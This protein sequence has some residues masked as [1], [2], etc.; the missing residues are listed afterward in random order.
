MCAP[1]IHHVH[2]PKVVDGY[3][4]AGV[5]FRFSVGD[6]SCGRA[7]YLLDSVLLALGGVVQTT[8]SGSTTDDAGTPSLLVITL[9]TADGQ[10]QPTNPSITTVVARILIPL[11]PAY[12]NVSLGFELDVVQYGPESSYVLT[13]A[14]GP[15]VRWF[16]PVDGTETHVPATGLAI[17]QAFLV[18]P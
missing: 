3:N 10:Q 4:V 1:C 12:V 9:S 8:T 14:A 5:A 11:T 16:S 18:R 13:L 6:S 15:P 17:A 7:T 2:I